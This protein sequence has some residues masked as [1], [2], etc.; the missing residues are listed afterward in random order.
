MFV[1]R[2]QLRAG[3]Q[4]SAKDPEN[5]DAVEVIEAWSRTLRG[6]DVEGAAEF[7]A[8]PSVAENG[9][10]IR[11]RDREDA[12]LFNASLPCG[13]ELLST[14]N[15]GDFITATFE[16]TERPGPGPAETA[17]ETRLRPPS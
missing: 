15:Q 2:R 11:I 12:V 4:P 10:L 16:L 13:A 3:E 8:L 7:F 6:G 14:E 9:A 5:A 17:R 1:L